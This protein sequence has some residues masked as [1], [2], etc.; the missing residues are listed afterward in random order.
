MRAPFHKKSGSLTEN[1][2]ERAIFFSL[3][4]GSGGMTGQHPSERGYILFA[5][6]MLAF[7][8]PM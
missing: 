1:G 8:G 7:C 2:N 5:D 4:N 6:K 3:G